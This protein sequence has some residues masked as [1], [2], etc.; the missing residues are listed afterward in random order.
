MIEMR[1]KRRPGLPSVATF[2]QPDN[3]GQVKDE[4]RPEGHCWIF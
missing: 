3:D 4:G 1:S 2:Q